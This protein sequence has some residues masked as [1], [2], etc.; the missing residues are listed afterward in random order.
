MHSMFLCVD[1]GYPSR[2]QPE[3]CFNINT[4][5]L[6]PIIHVGAPHKPEA[7]VRGEYIY[8]Y[9][10][11]EVL[12]VSHL[13]L[14]FGG[15]CGDLTHALKCLFF[16]FE[17]CHNSRDAATSPMISRTSCR[18]YLLL[19]IWPHHHLDT[20]RIPPGQP[21]LFTIQPQIILRHAWLPLAD[22]I[23]PTG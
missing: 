18:K 12:G 23:P 6:D 7:V 8:I 16:F 5:L 19:E 3:G 17:T 14:E 20:I 15:R 11:H 22:P 10:Y 2:R 13:S 21:F 4:H 1:S 9:I